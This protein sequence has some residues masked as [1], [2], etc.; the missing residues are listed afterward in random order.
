M[1]CFFKIVKLSNRVVFNYK[2]QSFGKKTINRMPNFDGI[3]IG[4]F[5]VTV[6]L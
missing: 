2:P 5:R 4:F 1:F 3:C 6:F